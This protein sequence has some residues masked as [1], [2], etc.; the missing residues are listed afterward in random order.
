MNTILIVDDDILF[1]NA[2]VAQLDF[3]QVGYQNVLTATDVDQAEELLAANAVDVLLCDIEMPG[4]T[5]MDLLREVAQKKYPVVVLL[6]T[7]HSSFAYAQEAIGLRVFDYLLKPIRIEA[8]QERLVAALR[9]RSE[10]NV[11]QIY[12]EEASNLPQVTDHDAV[13]RIRDYIEENIGTELTREQLSHA[14]FMSPDHIARIFRERCGVAL[15][16][17]IRSRRIAKAKKL[18]RKTSLPLTEVCA[19]VGYTY[20][21]Y[22]FNTFKKATGLSPIEY[23]NQYRD[24]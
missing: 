5:G 2:L 13:Q 1:L 6:L 3:S 23:R 12:R 24:D 19:Q 16:E 10:L 18:L 15:N 11:L 14:L 17:Y 20:N 22:F 8:L 7:C 21:T 4:K 9:Q